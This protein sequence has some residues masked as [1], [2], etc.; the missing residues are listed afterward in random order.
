[1]SLDTSLDIEILKE[2]FGLLDGWEDRYAYVLDLGKKLPHLADA[3]KQDIFIVRGCTSLVWLIPQMSEQINHVQF[4]ADSDAH[5]VRG[6]I[7]ILSVIYNNKPCEF[8]QNFDIE[9]YF[10]QLG[11]SEHL[12]PNR[13]N[14]FF[15][16]V[17]KIKALSTL[18]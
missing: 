16:M 10:D 12:T 18:S 11:L 17:G 5:L 3:E 15:S 4:K 9:S 2:N 13:R 7:A 14:G 6:L 8:V 1:M